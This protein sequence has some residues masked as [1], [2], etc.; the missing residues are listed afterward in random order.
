MK[1]IILQSLTLAG[2]LT[3]KL[4]ILIS[5]KVAEQTKREAK[6]RV[7]IFEISNFDAKPR[8]APEYLKFIFLTQGYASRSHVR[9]AQL[10]FSYCINVDE[11]SFSVTFPASNYFHKIS[12]RALQRNLLGILS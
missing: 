12:M 3:R 2:K 11:N 1:S 5:L 4:T 8:F 9:F 6:L 10:I 7:K